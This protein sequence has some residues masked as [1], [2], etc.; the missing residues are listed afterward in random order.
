MPGKAVTNIA[1]APLNVVELKVTIKGTMPM[2]QHQMSE[3]ARKQLLELQM[4]KVHKKKEPRDP[5]KEYKDS[6]YRDSKGNVAFPASGVKKAIVGAARYV[7]GVTMT[8]LKGALFVV[9][10]SQDL[11]PVQYKEMVKRE[12]W[13][14][15]SNG[16][17][18]LR[19]R[20]ELHDWSMDLVIQFDGDVFSAEQ[21]VNLV[22][23]AGFHSG[24]GEWRPNRD[25]NFGKFEVALDETKK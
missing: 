21:I 13:V 15:L 24:L 17:T 6:V 23:R 19:Y 12:D 22:N 14:R 9:G 18:D 7:D 5:E 2:I 10:D 1:V 8:M 20:A 11:I 16:S 25:G 4:K 3:K